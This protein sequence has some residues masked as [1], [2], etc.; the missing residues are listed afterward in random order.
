MFTLV[1]SREYFQHFRLYE[2]PYFI[3]IRVCP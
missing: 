3:T 1:V 2:L